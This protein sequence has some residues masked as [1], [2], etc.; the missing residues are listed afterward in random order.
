MIEFPNEMAWM[1]GDTQP[2]G[3]RNVLGSKEGMVK[4]IVKDLLEDVAD[5][6]PQSWTVFV[7]LPERCMNR[8]RLAFFGGLVP[9]IKRALV[10]RPWRC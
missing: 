10:Y 7:P 1:S 3:K 4:K 8:Q 6:E 9:H 2:D 5:V